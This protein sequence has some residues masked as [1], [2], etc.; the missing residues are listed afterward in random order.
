MASSWDLSSGSREILPSGATACAPNI[1]FGL[2]LRVVRR[3]ASGH[4]GS[5]ISTRA[6]KAAH[7]WVA[8]LG[9]RRSVEVAVPQ[10]FAGSNPAPRI[11]DLNA[12]CWRCGDDLILFPNA[13][14]FGAN[15]AFARDTQSSDGSL[16]ISESLTDKPTTRI[17]HQDREGDDCGLERPGPRVG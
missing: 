10:G 3:P 4:E 8:Q 17:R 2:R 16:S 11:F 9:Q 6:I 5:L 14:S 7:A 1:L 15:S 12:T 13:M